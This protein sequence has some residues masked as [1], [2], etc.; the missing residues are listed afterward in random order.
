MPKTRRVES[1]RAWSIHLSPSGASDTKHR[2]QTAIT[3]ITPMQNEIAVREVP[4]DRLQRANLAC[5]DV[6]RM[7]EKQA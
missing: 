2:L 7:L 5:G 1:E 3:Q 6:L 4:Q